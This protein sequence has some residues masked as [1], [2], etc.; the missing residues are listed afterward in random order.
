[1]VKAGRDEATVPSLEQSNWSW[2]SRAAGG[3]PPKAV[4]GRAVL[5]WSSQTINAALRCCELA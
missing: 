1:V 2:R 4:C 5:Y 3:Q